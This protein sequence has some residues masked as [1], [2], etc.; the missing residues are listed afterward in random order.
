MI[1]KLIPAFNPFTIV[2]AFILSFFLLLGWR[3]ELNSV[4][5]I[6]I[7]CNLSGELRKNAASI[8]DAWNNLLKFYS[9]E[10]DD[11]VCIADLLD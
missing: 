4:A 8:I 6:N 5:S 9:K 7:S 3:D 10:I 2:I 1:W 11:Q